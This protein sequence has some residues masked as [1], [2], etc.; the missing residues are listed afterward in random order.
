MPDPCLADALS[1]FRKYKSLADRALAQVPEAA[2]FDP[3]APDAN[4]IALVLKHMAGN[5]R[6]RWTRFLDSDGEKPDRDRDSEF[7]VRP[8][9]TPASIR[10]RWEEGWR[11]LFAALAPL[12]DPD[13]ALVVTIRGEPH[14]VREAIHRQLT[15]YAYHTGQ[16]VLLARVRA[17]AGWKSL[18]IPKGKSKEFEVAKD[19]RPYGTGK[20]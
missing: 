13:L 15:H 4:S 7:E 6:S 1:Q 17:G 11:L 8:G 9:D 5:M 10:A 3:P 2:W 18:S 12:G 19:G 14:T 20:P 16:I